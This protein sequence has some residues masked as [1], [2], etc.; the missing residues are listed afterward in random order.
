MFRE[1]YGFY[2]CRCCKDLFA[3]EKIEFHFFIVIL[4]QTIYESF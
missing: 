3:K 1:N 2:L 4:S